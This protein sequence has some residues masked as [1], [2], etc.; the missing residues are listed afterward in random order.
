MDYGLGLC[1]FRIELSG[2]SGFPIILS[3]SLSF[4]VFFFGRATMWMLVLCLCR[5]FPLF[6]HLGIRS[7]GRL[8]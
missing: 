8:G 7:T 1:A 5:I 3:L 6:S 4:F 2:R